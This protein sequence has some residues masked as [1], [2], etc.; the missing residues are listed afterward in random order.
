MSSTTATGPAGPPAT[1]TPLVDNAMDTG[2]VVL[3]ILVMIVIVLILVYIIRVFKT[4]ALK[5]V[6]LL[7]KIIALDTRSSL[8]HIVP[9]N[10]M[11]VTTR[12]QEFSYCF[13]IYLSE[14]YA[15]SDMHKLIMVRGNG[16]QSYSTMTTDANPV[17]M[18][19]AKTN[20]MYFALSTTETNSEFSLS[21][22]AKSPA[23]TCTATTANSK[24]LVIKVEYVPLQRWIN[25]CFVVRDNIATLFIDGDIYSI[26]TTNDIHNATSGPRP[27]IRG[28]TG[29]ISIGDPNYPI[30]GFLSKLEF[31]NYA[32]NHKQVQDIYKSGPV[33]SGFLSKFGIG[34]YGIRSPIYNLDDSS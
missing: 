22:I 8:P 11:S 6:E 12:G 13:W 20:S 31:F 17:I 5:R 25:C 34:N 24:H 3:V 26:S 9:A 2:I 27:I 18:M 15:A 23:T 1:S 28:T 7:D 32:L 19:D 29:K 14:N 33:N 16:S 30:N 4:S 10:L 21:C